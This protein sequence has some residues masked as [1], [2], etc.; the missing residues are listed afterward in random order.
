[1]SETLD[2]IMNDIKAAMKTGDRDRVT[3][4]RSIHA[5]VKDATVNKGIEPTDEIVAEVLAR[6]VKQRLESIRQFRDGGREDLAV[7]EESELAIL[8]A[9]QPEQ[10]SEDAIAALIRD[11]VAK[12]GASGRQD[13]GKVMG[14]LMPQ[15]KGK[16]DG[17]MVSRL[18]ASALGG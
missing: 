10:L 17:A 2:R 3:T 6:A 15:I 4:L 5:Q 8:K 13:M 1:M 11:A 16:A 18:V 9:Y 14:I 7:K 12:T